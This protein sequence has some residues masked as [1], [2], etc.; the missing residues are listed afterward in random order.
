MR[1]ITLFALISILFTSTAESKKKM[2]REPSQVPT[3][4]GKCKQTGVGLLS[5]DDFK[6]VGDTKVLECPLTISRPY[7]FEGTHYYT[8]VYHLKSASETSCSYSGEYP[9]DCRIK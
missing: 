2:V 8:S 4:V 1:I 6:P 9:I 7:I 5:F 3:V